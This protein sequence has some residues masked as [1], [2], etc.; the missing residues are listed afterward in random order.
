MNLEGTSMLWVVH[1]KISLIIT[2]GKVYSH[3]MKVG[4]SKSSTQNGRLRKEHGL[5]DRDSAVLQARTQFFH[6][7]SA[8]V[9]D[10]P[11]AN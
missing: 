6:G 1:V 3:Q 11:A 7:D 2:P 8:N 9:L 4:C 10:G 5:P